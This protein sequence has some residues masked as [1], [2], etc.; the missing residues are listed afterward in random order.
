MPAYLQHFEIDWGWPRLSEAERAVVRRHEARAQADPGTHTLTTLKEALAA[1]SRELQGREIR[2]HA[3]DEHGEYALVAREGRCSDADDDSF[4]EEGKFPDL[5]TAD[6][7]RAAGVEK[8][9]VGLYWPEGMLRAIQAQASRLDRSLSWVVQKA[10][11]VAKG[12]TSPPADDNGLPRDGDRR[13][14]SIYLPIEI[15]AEL[16]EVA[17]REDRS[18]S[19]LVQRALTTSWPTITTLPPELK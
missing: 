9:Y 5:L 14:Q 7:Y 1:S 4:N 3:E 18:M 6:D 10:W 17:A 2:S 13:K 15:Y 19:F 16:A 11:I 8:L 12:S